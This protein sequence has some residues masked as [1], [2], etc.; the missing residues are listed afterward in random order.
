MGCLWGGVWNI[1]VLL[2]LNALYSDGVREV[3]NVV[4]DYVGGWTFPRR[5]GCD[6][7]TLFDPKR[8]APNTKAG[9]F[10]CSASDGL[11][12]YSLLAYFVE[13]VCVPAG[14]CAAACVAYLA[15]ADVIDCIVAISRG[16]NVPPDQLLATVEHFLAMFAAAF[17]LDYM[18]PKFH[19]LLHLM[20]H[21]VNF[22]GLPTCWTLERK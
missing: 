19:W 11:S 10:K 15:L 14:R 17:G 1:T 20:D 21:Y 9:H 16:V 6:A 3:Y 18:T 4:R 7:A 5:G 22:G 2:L 12:L 13:T 8:R